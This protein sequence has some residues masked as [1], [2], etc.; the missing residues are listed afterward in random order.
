MAEKVAM[1]A[2]QRDKDHLYFIDSAGNISRK[3]RKST[4]PAELVAPCGI[5]R[6]PGYIYFIDKDGDVA[7]AA[8]P[9]KKPKL[10][11]QEAVSA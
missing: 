2:I 3:R 9:A 4:E 7:R 6:D 10:A 1:T 11:K 5:E 8:R